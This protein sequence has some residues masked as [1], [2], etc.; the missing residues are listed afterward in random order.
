M[1]LAEPPACLVSP[2]AALPVAQPKL[3][4]RKVIHGARVRRI[5]FHRQLVRP[6][7][8]IQPAQIQQGVPA[9]GGRG[10]VAQGLGPLKRLD[11]L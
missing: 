9:V 7:C 2:P 8:L 10:P 3:R 1:N 6:Q 5:A 4:Q 11:C